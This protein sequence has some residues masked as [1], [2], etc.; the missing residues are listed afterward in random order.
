MMRKNSPT[1]DQQLPLK[2]PRRQHPDK[3]VGDCDTSTHFAA[4]HKS[5]PASPSSTRSNTSTTKDV[6]LSGERKTSWLSGICRKSLH[7]QL[8]LC[9]GAA[10]AVF[11][12]RKPGLKPSNYPQFSS[13]LLAASVPAEPP[14]LLADMS[15]ITHLASPYSVGKSICIAPPNSSLVD[16][17]V[18]IVRC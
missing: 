3:D 12:A 13:C 7:R 6:S 14:T 11:P 10:E 1:P 18:G 8:T 5:P 9:T 2:Q 17:C 4:A 15:D 16:S